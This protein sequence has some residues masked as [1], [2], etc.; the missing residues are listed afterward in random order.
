[1]T[2]AFF[3]CSVAS[4]QPTALESSKQLTKPKM[5]RDESRSSLCLHLAVSRPLTNP[6]DDE[7][8]RTQR[9]HADQADQPAIVQIVLGHGRAI[10]FDEVSLLGFV[11]EQR[12]HLPLV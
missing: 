8:S 11:A 9:G 6:E 3:D 10:A 1:M 7:L 12:P 2:G 5:S 4:L